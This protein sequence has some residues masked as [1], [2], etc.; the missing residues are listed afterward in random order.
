MKRVIPVGHTSE[1]S[2]TTRQQTIQQRKGVNAEGEPSQRD[3]QRGREIWK[4]GNTRSSV[5]C[6]AQR[7]EE[8]PGA[9]NKS[10]KKNKH[11]QND[12]KNVQNGPEV[13]LSPVGAIIRVERR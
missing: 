6:I 8:E 10:G 13:V 2:A 12:H 11:K 9:S 1:S 4:K 5:R 7:E 3:R